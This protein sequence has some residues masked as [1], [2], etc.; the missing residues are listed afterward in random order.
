MFCPKCGKYLDDDTVFCPG[1]GNKVEGEKLFCNKCGEELTSDSDFCSKCGNRVTSNTPTIVNNQVPVNNYNQVPVNNY[2][3]PVITPVNTYNNGN[4][5]TPVN[6]YYVK[7]KKNYSGVIAFILL[8]VVGVLIF[9]YV[10][11]ENIFIDPTG[12]DPGSGVIKGNGSG[13]SGNGRTSIETEKTYRNVSFS[14]ASDVYQLID[15]DSKEQKQKCPSG[16]NTIENKIKNEL[17]IKA[18]N[19]CEIDT[20]MAEGIYKAIKRIFELFPTVKGNITNLS[21]MNMDSYNPGTIAFYQPFFPFIENSDKAAYKMRIM[22]NAKYFLNENLIKDAMESSS[23]AGHFPPNSTM[24]S[25]VVHEMGHYL[26]FYAMKKNKR[27]SQTLIVTPSNE[28]EVVSLAQ[29]FGNGSFS[30]KLLQEAYNLYLSEGNQNI[31]FDSWRGT[32][33]K[34]ALAKDDSGK[35]IYD[36]TIAEAFHDVYLN[37]NSAKPASKYIYRVLKKYVEA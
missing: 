20:S 24:Y 12:G 32:I 26:S 18:V 30:L 19:L 25:A 11:K 14:T 29:A 31:S 16:I 9:N 34:Y 17:D 28:N 23:K 4:V 10:K 1:C 13:S 6:T 36:E 8:I 35:Y 22:L 15:K 5:L 33:S 3:T 27:V 7:K 37:D 2:N 21:I